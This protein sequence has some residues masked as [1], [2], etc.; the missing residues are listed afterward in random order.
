[1]ST[2]EYLKARINNRN[3]GEILFCKIGVK[4]AVK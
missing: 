4:L 3:D 1:M 2:M